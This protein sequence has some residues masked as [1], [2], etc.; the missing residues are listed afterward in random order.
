MHII[1]KAAAIS[2][3]K[4]LS[5]TFYYIASGGYGIGYKDRFI[6]DIL[7]VDFAYLTIVSF[8][9][10]IW[11][12]LND[13]LIGV[14][15]DNIRTR[16]ANSSFFKVIEFDKSKNHLFYPNDDLLLNL[17]HFIGKLAN[18]IIIC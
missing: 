4:R 10:G 12:V 16:G 1:S 11:V 7:H 5:A 9:G 13:P 6:F 8:I 17:N 15:V 3:K 18:G 2:V 14:A